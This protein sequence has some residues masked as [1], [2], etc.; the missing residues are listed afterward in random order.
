MQISKKQV[1]F[2]GVILLI[3][4]CFFVFIFVSFNSFPTK[5]LN[6]QNNFDFSGTNALYIEINN[7]LHFNWVTPKKN[8]GSYELVTLDS[9]LISSGKTDSDRIHTV[10]LP[11]EITENVIFRFGAE[12]EKLNEVEL[13]PLVTQD[14]AILQNIDSIF[15]VGDVHGRYD[16]LINL[17]QK[18]HIVNSEL[19]WIAGKS[20]LIFLGDL[21]DRGD[22][23]TK[24][25]WFIYSLEENAKKNGGNVHLVLGNHEI[26]TMTKDLRYISKKEAIIA[27]IYGKKYDYLFHPTKSFLGA[28]LTSKPSV[29]K[30]DSNL[31]AH[32]GIVDLG[33]NSIPEFNKI[34]HDYMQDSM[35]LELMQ[36]NPDSLKYDLGVWNKMNN[37]FY[38]SKSPFWYRG[39]VYSDTLEPQLDAMLSKYKST[40]HIIAHTPLKTITQKYHGKLLTTDL[41]DA[42]TEL[43][44]LVR[45]QDFYLGYKIDSYGTVSKL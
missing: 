37:F 23:V 30:I 18:S 38:D 5:G 11:Y 44:L 25:L 22:D 15:V 7:G 36:E 3:A 17:L 20:N 9:I 32:G 33:T 8:I 12:N 4:C 43:L 39:Y 13:K 10:T 40:M 27:G 45:K 1:T 14:K 29:L 41:E 35:F 16:Q 26:M 28:W 24:V 34:A 21:F 42:A 19:Q 6:N 2:K 31:F